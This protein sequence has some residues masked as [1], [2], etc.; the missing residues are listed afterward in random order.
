M[1]Q[2]RRQARLFFVYVYGVALSVVSRNL[3]AGILTYLL[4][5]NGFR[6]RCIHSTIV[7]FT[8]RPRMTGR[9]RRPEKCVI[10][11]RI[12]IRSLGDYIVNEPGI[13][14]LKIGY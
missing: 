1:K 12:T 9:R 8:Q 10:L 4:L 3:V 2:A 7:S 6:V 5:D 13:Q 11:G 14:D